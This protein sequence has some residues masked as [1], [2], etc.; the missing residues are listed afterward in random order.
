[1][2]EPS[3]YNLKHLPGL[4]LPALPA[5]YLALA[6]EIG[7]TNKL[8]TLILGL[9]TFYLENPGSTTYTIPS[10]VKEVSAI[11]VAIIIFLPGI[12]FLFLGGGLSKIL[13]CILGGKEEYKGII[14]TSPHSSFYFSI[15]FFMFLQA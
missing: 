13:Y 1:M 2:N 8:S 12:P 14:L 5:L 9:N 7:E 6:L 3:V 11:L 4:V 10:I 15:S